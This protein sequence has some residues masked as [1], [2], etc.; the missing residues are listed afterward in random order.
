MEGLTHGI[1]D[2]LQ[3]WHWWVFAIVL[4]IFEVFS[5]GAFFMWLG[6]AAGATGLVL[7]ILPEMSWEIQFII[8]AATSIIAILVG[9]TFFGRKS[10]NTDDPTLSQLEKELTGNTYE[11]EKAIRN[12]S[13]RIKVGES[14][15]KAQGPDCE[16]GKSVKVIGV[17]GAV[18]L[19]E[20]V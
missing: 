1:F 5:P 4:V 8:F 6:A 13:G 12:G 17:K 3:F 16:A 11:V 9:R 2:N 10:V 15:W 18:L 19:V 20:P 7:L 14:T